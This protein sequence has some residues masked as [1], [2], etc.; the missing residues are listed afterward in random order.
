MKAARGVSLALAA[1]LAATAAL[2]SASG[3]QGSS[4]GVVKAP[5]K[6]IAQ[7]MKDVD[8]PKPDGCLTVDLA[9]SDRAWAFYGQTRPR[10]AGCPKVY[11]YSI[12][13]PIEGAWK[14]VG[15]GGGTAKVFCA[16]LKELLANVEAPSAVYRDFKAAGLCAR[17]K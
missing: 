5:P 8:L 10:P 7:M 2:A 11:E 3:A 17:G 15:A 14:Y 4:P 1:L 13:H 6:V 16:D 12:L 9:R